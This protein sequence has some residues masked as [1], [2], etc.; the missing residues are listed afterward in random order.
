MKFTIYCYGPYGEWIRL[1][2]ETTLLRAEQ[3]LGS[4]V[5][6]HC[7]HNF[8]LPTRW[9]IVDDSGNVVRGTK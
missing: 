6:T 8:D 9:R 5:L 2:D 4:L 7:E 3:R 1:A